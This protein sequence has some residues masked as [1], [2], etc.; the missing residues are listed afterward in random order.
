MP[1][2]AAEPGLLSTSPSPNP[3]VLAAWYTTHKSPKQ[4]PQFH[5]EHKDILGS[6]MAHLDVQENVKISQFLEMRIPVDRWTEMALDLSSELVFGCFSEIKS[7]FFDSMI[8]PNIIF[9]M[10][11]WEFS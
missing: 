2:D 8:F 11:L 3:V 6:A 7:K 1:S 5:R 4:Y 9:F 10:K